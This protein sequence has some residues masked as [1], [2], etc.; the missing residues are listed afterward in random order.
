MKYVRYAEDNIV[1]KDLYCTTMS[2]YQELD[3]LNLSELINCWYNPPID[4]DEYA[5]SY[6]S[7]VAS[8]IRSQPEQGIK[9]LLEQVK[10]ADTDRLG[11]ILFFLPPLD[12][13]DMS[14]ILLH[15]LD[16]ERPLIVANA[17]DGLVRQG[18][19]N[20]I[21]RVLALRTHPSAYVRGSVLRFISHFYPESARSLLI[22]ALQDPVYIV[23]ENAIDELEE[24]EV[25]EAIPYIR[26]LLLDPNSDVRLAAQ[27]AIENLEART[28]R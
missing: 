28:S 14:N 19:K 5:A 24:L 2:I 26:P 15:Y 1:N 21:D 10:K 23:R 18:E 8:A 17:I 9:F 13:S 7:E 12:S 25:V 27:T 4:G 16:D 22:E 3:T 20:A 6:Y 11:A